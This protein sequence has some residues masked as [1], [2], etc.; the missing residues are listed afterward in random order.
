MRYRV[1]PEPLSDAVTWIAEVGGRGTRGWPRCGRA[2][3]AELPPE[4][5][6][7]GRVGQDPHDRGDQRGPTGQALAADGPRWRTAC[8]QRARCAGNSP[9][10]CAMSAASR[11][12]RRRGREQ[13]ICQA[14]WASV[15]WRP[16]SRNGLASSAARRQRKGSSVGSRAG[17]PH[18][19]RSRPE[20]TLT[21]P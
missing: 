15:C 2:C 4:L 19:S 9:A 6:R 10:R 5:S 14:A 18:K 21:A 1:T 7:S 11:R 8:W 12:R 16:P 3:A 20:A 13:E 17:D